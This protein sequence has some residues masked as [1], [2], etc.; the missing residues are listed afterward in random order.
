MILMSRSSKP[1]TTTIVMRMHAW[2]VWHILGKAREG[3]TSVHRRTDLPAHD[4]IYT[5]STDHHQPYDCAIVF[6]DATSPMVFINKG[7]TPP[8]LVHKDGH[9]ASSNRLICKTLHQ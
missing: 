2:I 5:D 3:Q 1:T 8:P 7:N 6:A 4:F 9:P